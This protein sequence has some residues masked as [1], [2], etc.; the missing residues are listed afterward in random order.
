MP[1]ASAA[2]ST[3]DTGPGNSP[4]NTRAVSTW[5]LPSSAARTSR[6]ATSRTRSAVIPDAPEAPG[7]CTH[8]R[9]KPGRA[10][11]TSAYEPVRVSSRRST[12][13][14]LMRRQPAVRTQ[15]GLVAVPREDKQVR[16][17]YRGHH[18]PFG[19]AMAVHLAARAAEPAR[20]GS[21]Q[22]ASRRGG[23]F[24]YARA[25]V[26]AGL[27]AA[28]QPQVRAMRGLRQLR[29]G[30]VQQRDLSCAKMPMLEPGMRRTSPLEGAQAR[31]SYAAAWAWRRRRHTGA[32]PS[33]VTVPLVGFQPPG[34][35]APPTEMTYMS[36]V[37]PLARTAGDLPTALAVT[38]GPGD[39]AGLVMPVR[40]QCAGSRRR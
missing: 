2:R 12:F 18:L 31:P 15:P 38:A 25:G 1:S 28:E 26:A 40:D 29:R 20:G 16:V 10:G 30:D 21:K 5:R 3:A 37:G 27:A 11:L 39:A 24:R 13:S 8:T 6:S 9:S 35:S 33:V 34:P 4:S 19:L 14:R 17:G 23:E 22:V 32:E 7:T 36:A